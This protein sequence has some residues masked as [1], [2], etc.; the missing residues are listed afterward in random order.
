MKILILAD[1]EGITGVTRWRHVDP[2]SSDYPRFR[3]LMTGDVNAAVAGARA[4]SADEVYVTDGHENGTNILIEEL[5]GVTGFKSG[6][7]SPLSF[8]QGI[9]DAPDA[10]VCIG[11]HARMGTANAVCD[12]TLS[13]HIYDFYLNDRLCGEFGLA[14]ALCGH[15]NVPILFVSGDQAVCAEA[16]EW[17]PGVETVE[18]KR[19]TGRYSAECLLP[20]ETTTLIMKGVEKALRDFKQGIGT[21]PLTMTGKVKISIDFRNTHSAE[22][23]ARLKGSMRTDGRHVEIVAEDM[24]AVFHKLIELMG[25]AED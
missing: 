16:K 4:A 15:F 22:T 23:A 12:H 11:Y 13:G 18:V 25:L 2:N 24:L 7:S 20:E 1:M 17:V 6:L 3:K 9:Q 10:V 21:K 19:A 8:V 14:A 5:M